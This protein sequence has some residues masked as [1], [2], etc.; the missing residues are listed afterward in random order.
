MLWRVIGLTNSINVDDLFK[1]L[2]RL[3]L[4]LQIVIITLCD[5]VMRTLLSRPT[6]TRIPNTKS[7][8]R[9]EFWK[10]KRN[11]FGI[12]NIKFRE[13]I[14]KTSLHYQEVPSPQLPSFEQPYFL[15]LSFLS[16][17]LD[18]GEF[19]SPTF[20]RIFIIFLNLG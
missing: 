6:P 20:T 17:S 12:G 3:R 7:N 8:T 14:T 5:V 19:H 11:T 13:C 10:I 16:F 2:I 15:L 9:N 18:R 4:D 1:G